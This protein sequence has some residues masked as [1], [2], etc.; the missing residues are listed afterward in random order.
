MI[1]K[2]L[3]KKTTA[4]SIAIAMV[5]GV[6]AATPTWA[7]SAGSSE[8]GILVKQWSYD[9]QSLYGTMRFGSSAAIADLRPEIPSLE[10][11]TGSDEYSNYYPELGEYA[12]GI[13]RCFDAN[14]NLIWAKNTG[15]DESRS[16]P[17]IANILGDNY[18]EI[19]GGT[20]SGWN[21]EVM[22]RFG[23]FIWTFPSPPNPGGPFMWHSSPS[24]ADVDPS[25][26]GL[27]VFIGNNP[28]NSVWA[29]DG[30]NSD[31]VNDGI[32]PDTSWYP[33]S[34]GTEGIDWDVLWKF[35][36][37]GPVWSSPALGDVDN[38]GE[39]EVV[40]GSQDN[41]IYILNSK[42]GALEY[43]YLTGGIVDSTAALADIDGDGYLE[44]VIGSADNKVYS[45]QWD[46]STG[47]VEWSFTT[48]GPVYSSPA[49]GDIDGD[50][51]YEIVV[52]SEDNKVYGLSATGGM[53]WSYSTGGSVT[54]SPALANRGTG[55]LDVYVG[56]Y[57]GYLYL[58]DGNTGNLIDRF[59]TFGPL[60]TSPSVADADSDGKLEIFLY[61]A[62][63]PS[64][65]NH[66]TFWAIEDTGSSVPN[67]SVEWQNFRRDAK[68]T[69]FYPP[70]PAIEGRMTGGG[71][72]FN[73]SMRVTH[74]F[75]L[76]CDA[77]KTPNNLQVNWGKGN[78][79][80]L[81]NLNTASCSDDP[82]ITPNPPAAG[83]DTY[84]G[85]G[86]GRYNGVSGYT[87][88]WTFTDAGEPGKNDL[89]KIVIKDASNNVILS[90]SGKLNNGNQQAHKQ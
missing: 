74:G 19:I 17:V 81:E 47:T 41:Y 51:S 57:D 43:K 35:D 82:A 5:L 80:H 11:C 25:I 26:S 83:F 86:T 23:N 14:G 24:V 65:T 34:P 69:G 87:A 54:S 60:Y 7:T 79:F 89:A 53:E 72:V 2:E 67:H 18:L 63:T 50:G 56:S 10:I 61:D 90:V 46:G 77:S 70:L 40:I 48:G 4:I 45:L 32:T 20:T 62:G 30:D 73:A 52:G 12:N 39:I 64:T 71:S 13:W 84:V 36:T 37:G 3:G 1:D 58:I 85:T 15:T 38:D 44:I 42:T 49:I 6:F 29:F 55:G 16:S 78:K 76:N 75:E 21:V 59:L 22:D 33:Y 66:Y 8:N 28:Y 88:E 68:R 9:M 31:G 27:E